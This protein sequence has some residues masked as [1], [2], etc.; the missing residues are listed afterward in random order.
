M[1]NRMRPL[2]LITFLILLMSIVIGG[3]EALDEEGADVT[4]SEKYSATGNLDTSFSADATNDGYT[5]QNINLLDAAQAMTLDSQGRI[6]MTGVSSNDSELS[7]ARF[8][9]NGNLD[10]SFAGDGI[11]YYDDTGTNCGA[12]TTKG[13]DI[14]VDSY[15]FIYVAGICGNNALLIKV[16]SDGTDM[17]LDVVLDTTGT[18]TARTLVLDDNG[19]IFIAGIAGLVDAPNAYLWKLNSNGVL[20]DNRAFIWGDDQEVMDIALNDGYITAVSASNTGKVYIW[21]VSKDNLQYDSQFNPYAAPVEI[22]ITSGQN[23]EPWSLFLDDYNGDMYITGATDPTGYDMFLI[24]VNRSGQLQFS[25]TQDTIPGDTQVGYSV[26]LDPNN[27]ILV[28]GF[29]EAGA[30]KDMMI[31][32]F[33]QSGNLDTSFNGNGY[34]SFHLGNTSFAEAKNILLDNELHILVGGTADDVDGGTT[35]QADFA[36]WRYK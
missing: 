1:S 2:I 12:G 11:M 32:R 18:D 24:K 17:P 19:N 35:N 22:D 36:I 3:C 28:G 14:I 16:N 5:F 10:T 33:D 31:W 34:V 6:L 23:E 27:K 15:G 4:L 21:R 25:T 26:L 13:Y 9:T 20:L 7:I 29:N 30:Y 8:T